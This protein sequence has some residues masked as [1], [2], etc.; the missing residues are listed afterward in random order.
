MC[1]LECQ[2]VAHMLSSFQLLNKGP[3]VPNGPELQNLKDA[4][5][6]AVPG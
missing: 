5:H 2:V 1:T 4:K 6:S 3:E